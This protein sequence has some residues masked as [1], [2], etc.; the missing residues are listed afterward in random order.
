MRVLFYMDDL[1]L[2][3]RSREEAA[4]QTRELVTHLSNLGFA[5]SWKKSSPLPSQNVVY[6]G[7]EL[8][9]MQLLGLMS[10]GHVVVPLGL[11]HMRRLQRCFIRLR[12]NPTPSIRY[13]VVNTSV[14]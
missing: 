14:P 6:L 3:A 9:V 5:I 7:V 11:L 12:V 2:L 8:S 10:A 1:L 13:A 4:S